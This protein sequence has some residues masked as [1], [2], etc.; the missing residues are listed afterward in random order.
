MI[1]SELLELFISFRINNF[2]YHVFRNDLAA[3]L[4]RAFQ[5]VALSRL[6]NLI[7][8]E[9]FVRISAKLVATFFL[10]DEEFTLWMTFVANFT[11]LFSST[12][13]VLFFL[14][15]DKVVPHFQ[16]F[17]FSLNEMTILYH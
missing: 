10:G 7:L 9:V 13:Q 8:K 11:K 14:F 17:L 16:I 12:L 15:D 4:L 1:L 2:L 6:F 3:P 5:S